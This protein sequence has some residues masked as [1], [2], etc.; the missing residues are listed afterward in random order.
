[1]Q[2]FLMV[3]VVVYTLCQIFER[4]WFEFSSH[5]GKFIVILFKLLEYKIEFPEVSMKQ[6]FISSFLRVYLPTEWFFIFMGAPLIK[7][8]VKSGS[9]FIIMTSTIHSIPTQWL[10]TIKY[11]LKIKQTISLYF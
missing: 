8:F 1:M 6:R 2:K 5:H 9:F 11:L 7:P 10:N 3:A 4:D